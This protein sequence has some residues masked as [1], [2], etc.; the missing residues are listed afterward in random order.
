[1]RLTANDP[2]A[3]LAA[4]QP[5]PLYKPKPSSLTILST[6]RPRNASGFVCRL[7]LR[8]SSG[9]RTISPIPIKLQEICQSLQN[10]SITKLTFLHMSASSP[11][12]SLVQMCYRIPCRDS[13]QDS[14]E[15]MAVHHTCTLA[16]EPT[17]VSIGA[18]IQQHC[19][20][21]PYIQQRI[22]DQGTKRRTFAQPV[23]LPCP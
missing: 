10:Q 14:L 2:G 18:I 20:H 16:A 11:F 9:R 21:K 1:M 19:S 5:H 3:F 12:Q 15:Q 7:I 22:L 23:Q 4:V 8:T 17:T 6:P 13:L